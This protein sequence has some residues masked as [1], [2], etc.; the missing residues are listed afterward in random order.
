[1]AQA[2]LE[3]NT[4]NRPIQDQH[5]KRIAGQIVSGKWRYN[6]DTIK[7]SVDGGVLDGQHRLWAVMES[8][9]PIETVIVY[10]IE[11]EAFATIDTLRRPRSG[12]DVLALNG[13]SR[14]RASTSAALQWLIRWQRG[15]IENY[16]DAKNRVENSDV[17]LAYSENASMERAI[18]RVQCVKGLVNPALLGF[19]YF[20]LANRSPELAERM[21]NTLSN[22]AGVQINDP[23]F[24]LRMYFNSDRTRKD[25]MVTIAL[26][27][28]AAN[29]AFYGREIKNLN[30]I[31]QG[32]KPEPFP[33]LEVLTTIENVT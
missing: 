10:G 4:H 5:V 12:A 25:P 9:I 32:A 17:E 14:Y 13:V 26:M 7:V 24:R 18:E 6:G 16:R 28:K 30:W 21:I 15:C 1:M 27:I 29:A 23:F 8:K 22:P 33:K 20:V 31:S 3:H 2:L 11:K 19:F